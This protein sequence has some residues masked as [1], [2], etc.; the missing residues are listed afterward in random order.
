MESR[1]DELESEKREGQ[2]REGRNA[3]VVLI[4]IFCQRD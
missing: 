4:L 2:G 3:A 1:E